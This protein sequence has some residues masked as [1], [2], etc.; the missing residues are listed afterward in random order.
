MA[1]PGALHRAGRLPGDAAAADLGDHAGTGAYAAR[2]RAAGLA[3]LAGPYVGRVTHLVEG[4]G[5]FPLMDWARAAR[6]LQAALAG[7]PAPATLHAL[8]GTVSGCHGA[9]SLLRA[10]NENAAR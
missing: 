1:L 10:E 2:L 4:V 6:R 5:G 7:P 9:V 3:P 8:V